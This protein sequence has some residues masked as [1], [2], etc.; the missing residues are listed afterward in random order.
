MILGNKCLLQTFMKKI[1]FNTVL[2]C[3]LQILCLIIWDDIFVIST[4]DRIGYTIYKLKCYICILIQLNLS[5]SPKFSA[6]FI[7]LSFHFHEK[8]C[9]TGYAFQLCLM[10]FL[11]IIFVQQL[12][13]AFECSPHTKHVSGSSTAIITEENRKKPCTIFL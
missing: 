4:T 5:A 11:V 2:L 8:L 13:Y 10:S 3:A 1:L 12:R 7:S 6:S 9:L